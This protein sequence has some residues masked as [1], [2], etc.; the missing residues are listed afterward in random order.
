GIADERGF[1]FAYSGWWSD[2]PE[3]R[4]PTIALSF[5]GA[6]LDL[7]AVRAPIATLPAIGF[8]G[9]L[10]GPEV[11]IVDTLALADPFLARLPMVRRAPPPFAAAG[12]TW[13]IGHFE[14][15]IPSGYFSTLPPRTNRLHF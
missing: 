2:A 6:G 7:A 8:A 3:S 10:A 1:Y 12:R 15:A 4:R 11:H 5:V 14:R 13:R 9:Y